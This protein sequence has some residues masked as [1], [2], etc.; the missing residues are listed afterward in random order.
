MRNADIFL[1]PS[2]TE[3]HPQVLGQAAGSG[4][5]VIARKIYR[6]DYVADGVTGFLVSTDQELCEKLDMLIQQPALRRA[7]GE[8]AAL[9]AKRFDWD[10]IAGQWQ[11]AFE[12][13]VARRRNY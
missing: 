7:M 1:F 4:L 13:A 6:P 11:E 12:Q 10:V 5:P 8:S 2:T 3:G 9:H